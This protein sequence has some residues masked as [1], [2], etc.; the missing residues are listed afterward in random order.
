MGVSVRVGGICVLK[1]SMIP[2]SKDLFLAGKESA[3]Q[4]SS[5]PG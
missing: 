1:K 4:Q 2:H 3:W 5:C